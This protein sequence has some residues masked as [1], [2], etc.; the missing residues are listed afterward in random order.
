MSTHDHAATTPVKSDAE[1]ARA[2]NVDRSVICRLKRR[3]MPTAS[4]EAAQAW[5]R[6]HLRPALMKDFNPTRVLGFADM[7]PRGQT[8]AERAQLD[9]LARLMTLG[10]AAVRLEEFELV[11][12]TIQR[13]M[14]EIPPYL[15]ERAPLADRVVDALAAWARAKLSVAWGLHG[16]PVSHRLRHADR[17]DRRFW[18]A[19]VADEEPP[20]PQFVVRELW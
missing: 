2:L 11:R 5:R 15:R 17:T 13:T 4:V 6:R 7:K 16:H 8:K 20:V 3:G 12:P 9:R 1:L 19:F 10:E 18:Y 14:R